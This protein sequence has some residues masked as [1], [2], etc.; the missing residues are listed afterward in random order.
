MKK[1][2]TL[3]LA[4]VCANSAY[5][6]ANGELTTELENN[7]PAEDWQQ[8]YE[9]KCKDYDSLLIQYQ[10]LQK[11]LCYKEQRIN[12]A[13]EE[14]D[15]IQLNEYLSGPTDL[16]GTN[17]ETQAV[18]RIL[19]GQEDFLIQLDCDTTLNNTYKQ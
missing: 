6:Q 7:K 5:A 9:H 10:E 19:N 2:V 11:E 1:L 14:L 4:I 15:R 3:L 18:E 16:Y 17:N 13:I 8:L 12:R